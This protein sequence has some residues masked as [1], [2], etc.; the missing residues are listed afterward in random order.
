MGI[1]DPERNFKKI[2]EQSDR[3]SLVI[4]GECKEITEN[5]SIGFETGEPSGNNLDDANEER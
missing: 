2:T 4:E 5:I 3:K 1:W